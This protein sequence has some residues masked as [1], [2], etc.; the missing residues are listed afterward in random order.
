MGLGALALVVHA[1][2]IHAICDDAFISLRHAQNLALHGSPVYNLGE[3]VEGYTSPSWMVL[4]AALLALGLDG[5][6]A[7]TLLGILAGAALVVAV[8]RLWTRVAPDKPAHGL[9]VVGLVATST[10]IAAWTSSGL[11]TPL[12]TALVALAIAELAACVEEATRSRAIVAGAA[13]ALAVL[14]RPEGALVGLLAFGWLVALKRPRAVALPFALTAAAPVAAFVLWR[15]LYYG[16]ILPNTYTAKT[17]ATLHDRV[18]FGLHYAWFAVSE[19][20][21]GV[22]AALAAGLLMPTR[23]TAVWLA[24]ALVVPWVLMVIVVGGDF[25]DL[26]RF[27]V[28]I[29]PLLYVSLVAS[30]IEVGRKLNATRGGWLL[31]VALG[32]PAWLLGQNMLRKRALQ[33]EEPTREALRIEP[34]GWTKHHALDWEDAGRFLAAHAQPGDTMADP[35]A[36]AGPFYAGLPNIDVFGI[37]DA[38]VARHGLPNGNRPGHQ[39]FASLDYVLSRHPT[40]I[41]FDKCALPS[42]WHGWRWADSGYACVGTMARSSFGG[43]LRLIFLVDRARADALAEEGVVR[44]LEPP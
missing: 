39:R 10:P 4:S 9:L 28:P 7:L 29:L 24:R 16:A 3:R 19:M 15:F 42:S 32:A 36:G 38:E 22:S 43:H 5:R 1:L 31:A 41:M 17:A 8:W 18:A 33:V 12:F 34:L 40:F 37:A 21:Y 23:S 14:T 20:G 6:A 44:V 30:G 27:F 35:A 2:S 13:V 11:E 25:L 26:F